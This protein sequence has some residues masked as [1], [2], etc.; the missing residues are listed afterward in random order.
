MFR[1]LV[2]LL[3]CFVCANSENFYSFRN[4]TVWELDS[5]H[6]YRWLRSNRMQASVVQFYSS[7]SRLSRNYASVYSEAANRPFIWFDFLRFYAVNCANKENLELCQKH[8]YRYVPLVKYFSAK[9]SPVDMGT[10]IH[11]YTNATSLLTQVLH[12][13]DVDYSNGNCPHCQKLD[14]YNDDGD[15]LQDIWN[16]MRSRCFLRQILLVPVENM[17]EPYGV[18][19]TL[20]LGAA[21]AHDRYLQKSNSLPLQSIPVYRIQKSHTLIRNVTSTIN[22]WELIMLTRHDDKWHYEGEQL[23]NS[24]I[25]GQL[26]VPARLNNDY[27]TLKCSPMRY[28]EIKALN[29]EDIISELNDTEAKNVTESAMIGSFFVQ[30]YF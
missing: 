24:R 12:N 10:K 13:L 18:D 21:I 14:Y 26:S 20:Q 27:E 19:R 6:F 3:A 11:T 29:F 17:N 22:K 1:R 16:Y 4:N 8:G 2:F 30:H 23:T 7:G 9:S 5:T 25:L 15:A 28:D